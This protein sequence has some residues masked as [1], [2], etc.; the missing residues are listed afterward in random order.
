[1]KEKEP[2][3]FDL[4]EN[5]RDSLRHAVDHLT[6]AGK[7]GPGDLKRAIRD[8]AQ[9]VE[10]LLKERLRRIHQAFVWENVDKYPLSDSPTVS[11]EKAVTR[12]QHLGGIILP[13]KSRKTIVA[14][15][16]LRNAI[17]HFEFSLDLQEARG[18]VG[19]LLSFI[20]PVQ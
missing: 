11:A 18:I 7:P 10:L 14:A 2:V 20:S 13:E 17:E 9:V 15:R 8:I 16:T 5:A 4:I 1:M 19:R 6:G 12:L 3:K